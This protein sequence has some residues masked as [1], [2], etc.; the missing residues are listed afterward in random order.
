MTILDIQKHAPEQSRFVRSHTL[1]CVENKELAEAI[2]QLPALERLVLA[3]LYV[4]ELSIVE[5]ALVID[6]TI[7]DV[8]AAHSSSTVLLQA[9]LP[10]QSDAS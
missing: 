4:E 10:R 9:F 7:A 5:T 1:A 6:A 8:L 3:L 2:E